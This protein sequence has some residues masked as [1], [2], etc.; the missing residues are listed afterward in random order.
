MS[1][2]ACYI[3]NGV[4]STIAYIG[5]MSVMLWLISKYLRA[6]KSEQSQALK[7][8]GLSLFCAQVMFCIAGAVGSIFW[9]F[10]HN[11]AAGTEF[12]VIIGAAIGISYGVQYLLM[13]LLLFCRLKVVFDGTPYKISE[14]TQRS[15]TFMY[16][17]LIILTITTT[18]FPETSAGGTDLTAVRAIM[19][20]AFLGLAIVMVAFLSFLFV[21]RLVDVNKAMGGSSESETNKLLSQITKQTILTLTSIGS[22]SLIIAI[23]IAY[24]GAEIQNLSSHEMFIWNLGSMVDVWTNFIC[25]FLGF[26]AFTDYYLRML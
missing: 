7:Y 13:L 3:E 11:C 10:D 2:V 23:S 21:K 4:I 22:I 20:A 24:G 18:F 14:C 6:M 15:Y 17:T 5:S 8:L 16:A 19:N 26:G 1:D 9:S 25:I 12:M